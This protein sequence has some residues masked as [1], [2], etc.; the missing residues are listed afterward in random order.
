MKI[1]HFLILCSIIFLLTGCMFSFDPYVKP[2]YGEMAVS[3]WY[4]DSNLGKFRKQ[5]ENID[6]IISVDCKYIENNKNKY[7]FKCKLKIKEQGETVIPLSKHTIKTVYAVFIK[8]S[9]DK[10]NSKV[11]NSK[12]SNQKAKV[13]K[14]DKYLNY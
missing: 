11:Y 2:K 9:E 8:E 4:S 1:K 3:A 13:W 5:A 12:Y 7:V 6:E 14:N 10:Y